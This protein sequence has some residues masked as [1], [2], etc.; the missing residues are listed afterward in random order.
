MD[1]QIIG[2]TATIITLLYTVLGLPTQIIKNNKLKSVN[3]IS[4]FMSVMLLL[5][6]TSWVI[7]AITKNDYYILISNLPG[8]ICALIILFQFYWFRKQNE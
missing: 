2:T 4:R 1:P 5:T 8:A 3:G 7:Y 6:F